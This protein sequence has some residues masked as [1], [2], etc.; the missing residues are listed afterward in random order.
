MIPNLAIHMNREVN[1]GYKY[2]AQK[3][4]LPLYGMSTAKDTF[5][6]Q[7][8]A[9]L[10]YPL[11]TFSDTISSYIIENQPAS[12][13]LMKN[14]SLLHSLMIY[15]VH[16]HSDERLLVRRKKQLSGYYIVYLITKKWE[17]VPSRVLHLL[18]YVIPCSVSTSIRLRL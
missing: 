12:G 6:K 14:S 3:D 11:M 17:V 18:F 15:N 16:F 5:M 2:N 7:S 1:S 9:Q 13:E 8:L 10:M 4:M